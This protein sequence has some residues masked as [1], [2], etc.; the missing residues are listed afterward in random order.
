MAREAIFIGYRR[1][2]TADVAGRVY[3]ALA[4]RFGRGSIFKDVDNLRPGADFGAYI[5]TILPR[6]RVVL[7]LIGPNWLDSRDEA[8]RRRLD[9]PNDWVR[10][11]IETALDNDN[12]D[13]VPVLVNG[14]RM[15]RADELPTSLQR[16]LRRHA[17]TIRRDPD[18]HD[19]IN[20]LATAL[21]A[22]VKSGVL[23]LASLGGDRKAAAA[24]SGGGG[25][26]NVIMVT[27]AL[28]AA[29]FGGW[30][31]LLREPAQTAAASIEGRWVQEGLDCR[32]AMRLVIDG[33]AL[34][35]LV[36][37]AP[38]SQVEITTSTENGSVVATEEGT[39]SRSGDNLIARM[40]DGEELTFTPC[41]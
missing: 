19:D 23:D 14:A 34:N 41:P 21:R 28:A 11:E 12:L 4:A 6:C 18:F 25:F 2:D 40:L 35:V 3:D 29:A 36:P 39:Y 24:G 7:V 16:L 15:P 1:D 37:G 5:R 13:V 10:I 20:R 31:F 22:S 32:D 27:L 17:A 33:D 9:D 30:Y 8:G 26:A 38:A